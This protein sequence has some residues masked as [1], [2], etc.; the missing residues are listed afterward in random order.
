MKIENKTELN[1]RELKTEVE[2]LYKKKYNNILNNYNELY[3]NYSQKEL[4][5]DNY[6]NEILSLLE[7]LK[8]QYENK[9]DHIYIYFQWLSLINYDKNKIISHYLEI[10]EENYW[11]FLEMLPPLQM[12]DNSFYMQEFLKGNLT[13]FFYS[14]NNKYYVTVKKFNLSREDF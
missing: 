5:R 11:Y 10:T 3:K 4:I 8:K 14:K 9:E 2:I 1:I 6:L 12:K 7:K 13:N